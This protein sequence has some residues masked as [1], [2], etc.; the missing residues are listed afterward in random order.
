M[1][2][3]EENGVILNEAEKKMLSAEKNFYVLKIKNNGELVMP[4][5][6]E[7]T[8]KDGTKQIERFPA[9]I[10]RMNHKEIS[11]MIATDKEVVSFK[12]DPN[13]ETTDTEVNNN[14]FP[15]TATSSSFDQMKSDK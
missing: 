8:Y 15:R 10:W 4:L 12:L 5:I 7:I 9:E 14:T 13:L 2:R 1:K 11:K 3:M 6:V